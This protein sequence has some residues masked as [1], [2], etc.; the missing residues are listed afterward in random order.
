MDFD[1]ALALLD[2]PALFAAGGAPLFRELA[3]ALHP[4][5]APVDR[6]TEA[7]A[8][9]ARLS[10]LWTTARGVTITSRTG[11]YHVGDPVGSDELADYYMQLVGMESANTAEDGDVVLKVAR[12]PTDND[13]FQREARVLRQLRRQVP[14]SYQAYV[15]R[16]HDSFV[17]RDES[18]GGGACGQRAPRDAGTGEPRQPSVQPGRSRRGWMWRRLLVALG[19]AHRAGVVHGAVVPDHVLIEPTEHGLVLTN[20]CYAA[21]S[22]GET[23]PAVVRRYRTWYA[24]EI[25]R[26]APPRIRPSGRGR[27]PDRIQGVHHAGQ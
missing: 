26:S 16:L 22:P 23:V 19:V 18:S 5:R 10:A 1:S 8:A 2:R 12:R 7:T 9:F 3:K 13:L 4:D 20:W 24:P 14:P 15:P 25:L 17:Y 21:A 11:S 6:V 27:P